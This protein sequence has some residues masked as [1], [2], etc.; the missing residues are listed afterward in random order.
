M[1]HEEKCGIA[2]DLMPLVIDGVAGEASRTLVE[3]HLE[4]CPDCQRVMADMSVEIGA[5]VADEKDEKFIRFC[6]KLRRGLSWKRAL[7]V[8]PLTLLV[9]FVAV[10]GIAF[11]EYKLVIERHAYAPEFCELGLT[12][13]GYLILHYSSDGMSG[14]STG[15]IASGEEGIVHITPYTNIWAKLFGNY[16]K[17]ETITDNDL[18][19]VDGMIRRE[20][21]SPDDFKA[22][23]DGKAFLKPDA[24]PTYTEIKELRIGT[25]DDYII[26]YRAGDELTV[27]ED[28]ER[29]ELHGI[30]P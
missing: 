23:D 30:N 13:R 26:A 21:F 20:T 28:S 19:W 17:D 27:W 1:N 3:A 14:T 10:L 4:E 12:E 6:L 24:Q 29:Y 7:K 15:G 5:G 25:L 11:A 8:I 9:V 2:R 18:R 22:G 16:D